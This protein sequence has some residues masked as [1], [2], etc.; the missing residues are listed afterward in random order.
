MDPPDPVLPLAGWPG[1]ERLPG[2]ARPELSPEARC[3]ARHGRYATHPR[4]E[5]GDIGVHPIGE[6]YGPVDR[7]HGRTGLWFRSGKPGPLSAALAGRGRH[8]WRTQRR[9]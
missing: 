2:F 8:Y 6:D 3:P 7:G 9:G 5:G 4:P 1:P